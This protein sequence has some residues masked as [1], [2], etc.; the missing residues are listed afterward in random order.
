MTSPTDIGPPLPDTT[1][2][3]RP[4]AQ[5]RCVGCG[6]LHGSVN[7][8]RICLERHLIA[9]RAELEPF[10]AMIEENRRAP[11][12]W[13]EKLRRGTRAQGV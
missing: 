2:D 13:V 4:D 11:L 9:A 6:G 12:S 3:M 7:R 5:R 8:E 1:N 10:K